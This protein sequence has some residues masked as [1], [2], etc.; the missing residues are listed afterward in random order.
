MQGKLDTGASASVEL[1]RLDSTGKEILKTLARAD[2][3]YKRNRP[4]LC[5]F[6]AKG[7]C[8]RGDECPYR[9]EDSHS[10]QLAGD[11]S[12]SDRYHGRNDPIARKILAGFASQKGLLPPDDR[13]ITS[14]FLS[15]LPSD[16][17]EAAIRATLTSRLGVVGATI[18]SVVVVA[19][20]KC[21][22]VNFAN[23]EAAEKAAEILAI[24]GLQ[25]G[26]KDAR[27]QWGR[28]R[29]KKA[30]DSIVAV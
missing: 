19:S 27:L 10:N 21:A 24:G 3:Y 11:Q 9:H 13:S 6:Y 1:S 2:P 25:I 8:T 29:A 7:A 26:E 22:F 28:S 17:S 4:Q 18:K 15:S 20:S 5:S 30:R 16:A 23:R 14:L 12:I